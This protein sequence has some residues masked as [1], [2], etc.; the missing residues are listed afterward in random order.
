MLL[1]ARP[2]Q[3]TIRRYLQIALPHLLRQLKDPQAASNFRWFHRPPAL[4]QLLTREHR[5]RPAD[6]THR[7]GAR[8]V[9]CRISLHHLGLLRSHLPP[10]YQRG[11]HHQIMTRSKRST[12]CLSPKQKSLHSNGL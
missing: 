2:Q 6:Q 12:A 3:V 9:S 8:Q 10:N 1:P 4:R 5:R 11:L 7:T